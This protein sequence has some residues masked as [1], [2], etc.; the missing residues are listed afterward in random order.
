L[1]RKGAMSVD[2]WG[3]N[4]LSGLTKGGNWTNKQWETYVS[5]NPALTPTFQAIQRHNL[6]NPGDELSLS[7]PPE[8][9]KA[10]LLRDATYRNATANSHSAVARAGG[11]SSIPGAP[12]ARGVT[13]GNP[14][15][16]PQGQASGK[17]PGKQ[18]VAVV[19]PDGKM[20][21]VYQEE[22]QNALAAGYKQ[23]K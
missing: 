12:V 18:T 7:S 8:A 21:R 22:L 16:T 11:S 10:S 13:Q 4:V 3:D 15:G 1:Y 17:A 20:V 14:R 23:V 2:D 19:G 6:D 9:I 5:A